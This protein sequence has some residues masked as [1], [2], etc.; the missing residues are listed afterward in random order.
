M[1]SF[2]SCKGV[3][4][5][6]KLFFLTLFSVCVRS[7]CVLLGTETRAQRMQGKHAINEDYLQTLLTYISNTVSL[8]CSV[9]PG[10]DLIAYISLELPI[11]LFLQA[12]EE[13]E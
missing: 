1:F 11:F 4:S 8:S 6:Q 7:V 13:L 9:W 12:S 10:T 3:K 5:Y 2:G